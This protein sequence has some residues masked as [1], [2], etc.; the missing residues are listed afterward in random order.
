VVNDSRSLRL[1]ISLPSVSRLSR[2]MWEPRRL[3]T[4]WASVTCL[5]A[6]LYFLLPSPDSRVYRT[7]TKE[8]RGFRSYYKMYFSPYTSTV[9]SV[10][11]CLMLIAG[12]RGQFPRWRGSRRRLSVSGSV[13]TVHIVTGWYRLTVPCVE[14]G[15][16]CVRRLSEVPA[17]EADNWAC[18][19]RRCGSV[20]I[21]AGRVK[22]CEFC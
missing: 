16:E 11:S 20:A 21:G 14:A 9:Y 2:G 10:S 19:Q 7:Y 18:Q 4:L 5:Q 8:W 1:I 6:W 3:R 22:R 17:S 15:D 13:L 12:P